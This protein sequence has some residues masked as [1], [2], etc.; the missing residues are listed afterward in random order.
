ML[1]FI[2][3]HTVGPEGYQWFVWPLLG[4]GIGLFFHFMGVFAFSGS[5]RERMIHNEMERQKKKGQ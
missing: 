5:I 4:W 1:F 2:N 3:R